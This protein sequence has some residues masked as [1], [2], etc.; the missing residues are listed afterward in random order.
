MVRSSGD[1][2]GC[3]SCAGDLV[4][5]SASPPSTRCTQMSKFA[6]LVGGVRDGRPSGDQVTS[7]WSPASKVRRVN[8]GEHS[9]RRRLIARPPLAQASTRRPPQARRPQRARRP[10]PCGLSEARAAGRLTR[11]TGG[12]TPAVLAPRGWRRSQ[13]IPKGLEIELQVLHALV[14]PLAILLQRL[15]DDA[16][17]F[18]R[19]IGSEGRQRRGL[20]LQNGGEHVARTPPG[21]RQLPRQQLVEHDTERPDI[22]AAIHLLASGLLGRHVRHRPH[23]RSRRSSP[24]ACASAPPSSVPGAVSLA[25]PKSSTLTTRRAAGSRSRASHRDARYPRHGPQSAPTAI[26]IVRSSAS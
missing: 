15:P 9:M 5:C 24:A 3:V 18:G 12:T 17:Q 13:V 1:Q 6:T 25:R 2:V 26:W 14:A 19:H 16:V 8:D 11:L 20:V 10:R 21:K 7:V 22:G 23:A 4:I